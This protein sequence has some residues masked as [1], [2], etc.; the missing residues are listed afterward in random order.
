MKFTFEIELPDT[1]VDEAKEI[2]AEDFG[3]DN[4]LTRG[5]EAGTGDKLEFALA[6]IQNNLVSRLTKRITQAQEKAALTQVKEATKWLK[7]NISINIK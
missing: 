4:P 7:D 1:L 6:G 5:E 3:Y 2:L